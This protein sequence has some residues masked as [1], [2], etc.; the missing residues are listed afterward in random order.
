MIK[1]TDAEQWAFNTL[2][3]SLRTITE[4]VSRAIEGHKAYIK[5][6][7]DKYHAEFDPTTGQFKPKGEEGK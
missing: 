5:L 7:E 4:G 3:N 2:E 6:L 1:I